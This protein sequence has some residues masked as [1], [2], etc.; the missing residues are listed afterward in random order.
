MTRATIHAI[1]TSWTPEPGPAL[2]ISNRGMVVAGR[3][4]STALLVQLYL[5]TQGWKRPETQR[6]LASKLRRFAD[7]VPIL[8]QSPTQL[9]PYLASRQAAVRESTYRGD[10]QGLS[11]FFAWC[12]RE[13]RAPNPMLGMIGP[14]KPKTIPQRIEEHEATA[15]Y[16]YAEAHA[17]DYPEWLLQAMLLLG[18]G[19]RIGELTA[20]RRSHI[21][22]DYII[23]PG[24]KSGQR[25][26]PIP[27][28][29]FHALVARVGKGDLL[30]VIDGRPRSVKGLTNTWRMLC[31]HV[32]VF[33]RKAGPH[34][35]RHRFAVRVLKASGGDIRLVQYLL[36]HESLSST[37]IYLKLIDA[38][39]VLDRW[40]ALNPLNG[41]TG[42]GELRG[43]A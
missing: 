15:V 39:D 9:A 21:M 14:R 10:F 27:H 6:V 43:A 22:R 18:T 13:H 36:G 3:S 32:G 19:I 38:G 4:R 34:A 41:L 33:G 2:R 16:G 31:G 42:A 40:D 25:E 20:M 11:R 29:D 17:D 1:D 23:I 12:E 26:V 8:P 5:A 7:A 35:A 30:W 24:G 37:V 28:V